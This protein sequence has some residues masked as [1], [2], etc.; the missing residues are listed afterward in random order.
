MGRLLRAAWQPHGSVVPVWHARSGQASHRF[1]ILQ[2]PAQLA[3]AMAEA[4]C[5]LCLAGA[6]PATPTT[7]LDD[8]KEIARAVLDAAVHRP[9]F[10]MSS[11][12]VY[13]RPGD[14]KLAETDNPAP[15]SPYGRAKLEMEHVATQAPGPVTCLRLGN[16]LGADALLG[17]GQSHFILDQFPGG[18]FPERSYI[19]P[20]LFREI[21]CELVHIANSQAPMPRLL[22]VATPEPVSMADLLEA[23]GHTWS[24]RQAPNTAIPRV[25]LDT[26]R[27]ES[28][29]TLPKGASAAEALVADWTSVV[30]PNP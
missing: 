11:A 18:S 29:V 8:N 16:L 7:G 13:G 15:T 17:T 4:D 6:T 25:H 24:A 10:L 1:D 3:T 26:S 28:L 23:A 22:N 12:A 14:H 20:N 30:E 19:G 2:D 9:V 21:L 27:L 5:V